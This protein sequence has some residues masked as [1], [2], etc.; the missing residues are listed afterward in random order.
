MTGAT[1]CDRFLGGRLVL[2][3]PAR[4]HRAGTDAILLVAGAKPEGPVDVYD[5]GAGVGAAGLGL[6]VLAPEA[7]IRLV[8]IDPEVAGLAR[9]N[10]VENGLADRVEVIEA[11]LL[12]RVA[13]LAPTSADLVLMNPPF[14]VEGKVRPSPDAYRRLAHQASGAVEEG[15]IRRAAS[16]LR[17]SAL[18]VLVHRADALPRLLAALDRRFGDVRI[19]PVLPRA[20]EPATRILVRARKASRAPLSLLPPLVLHEADGRFT[21]LAEALNTGEAGIKW[22]TGKGLR[23]GGALER[24]VQ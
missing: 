10:I 5:L 9:R 3:Q 17:P 13:S 15:W 11:D 14:H 24:S 18:L 19:V 22:E 2:H 7:R 4:G 20:D 12:G 6:A 23:S 1:T 21:P 16:L 8:E